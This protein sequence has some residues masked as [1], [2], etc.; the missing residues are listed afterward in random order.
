MKKTRSKKSRD[1]VPLNIDQ[2]DQHVFV[3][4]GGGW[5]RRARGVQYLNSDKNRTVMGRIFQNLKSNAVFK[6][7]SFAQMQAK[8]AKGAIVCPPHPIKK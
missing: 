1:T 2:L 5:G 7:V 8:F 6:N 4:Q 3:W